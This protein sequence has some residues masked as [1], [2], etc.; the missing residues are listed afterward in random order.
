[1]K[2]GT[3]AA[4]I[5]AAGLLAAGAAGAQQFTMKL[6]SPTIAD[7]QEEWMKAFKA[8]VEARAANRI[9]VEIYT[10]NRLG[11]IPQTVEGVALG[12]IELTAPAVGFFV[13][14]EPRFEALDAP[15]LFDDIAHGARVFNDPQ[16]R[17]RLS[18]FGA[19]KGVEPLY[20]FLNQQQVLASHKAIRTLAD[21]KGQK[22][23][24][25]GAAPIQVEPF[26]RLGALPLAMP[27]G[28]V[29]AAMQNHTI[30]GAIA[31]IGAFTAFKYYDIVKPLTPLPRSFLVVSGVA[32][33]NFM[34]SL[35]RDLEALVREESR[36]AESVFTDFGIAEV[37]RNDKL[38]VA[39]GG[40]IIKFS[41]ADTSRY[42]EQTSG[43]AQPVI[44]RNVQLKQ[45]YEALLAAS[46]KYR[47]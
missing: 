22:I 47:K 10:A 39:N 45:D 2:T 38:W 13:G 9:K 18:S 34:T 31:G 21:F 19:A 20:T 14:L 41:A 30:D 8:G 42:L 28:E 17:A 35:G 6:S 7:A 37:E 29:M 1:M 16:I 12:T 27:L 26:K 46:K 25:P 23:R 43:A 3:C 36:K 40:E 44:A 33:R 15:G 11:Q 32:N 24:M 4:V 5:L